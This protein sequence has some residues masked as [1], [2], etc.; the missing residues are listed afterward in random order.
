MP[1][2]TSVALGIPALPSAGVHLDIISQLAPRLVSL[3]LN[4]DWLGCCIDRD[5]RSWVLYTRRG[6][7]VSTLPDY[8][9]SWQSFLVGAGYC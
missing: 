9:E 3:A 6:P 1:T 2:L 8:V 5:A 4:L 7:V